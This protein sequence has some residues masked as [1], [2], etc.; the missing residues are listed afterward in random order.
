VRGR[1]KRKYPRIE[2]KIKVGFRTVEDL[3]SEYAKNISKGGIFLKTDRLVDPNA[4]IDLTL[5]F[6][7]GLGEYQIRGRVTRLMSISHP[8]D[9]EIQ[10]YGIGVQFL[11]P[12]P[13]FIRAI[14]KVV[15]KRKPSS[16]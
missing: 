6:P 7:N 5:Q 15:Q 4:E 2:A 3:V 16:E 1:E 10:L 13:E 14:E 9:P 8:A 11:S 12:D